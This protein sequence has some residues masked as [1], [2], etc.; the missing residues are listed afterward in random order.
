V[1]PALGLLV[2]CAVWTP[3]ASASPP[4]GGA[5]ASEASGT[6]PAE[7]SDEDRDAA[8][9]H[10]RRGKRHL[11]RGRFEEALEEFGQA[12]AL[13]PHWA[14]S[15]SMGVCHD[16]LGRPTDALRLY[17]QAL[18]EGGEEIPEQQREEL[19]TRVSALRI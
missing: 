16:R 12:Y 17:E 13:Y 6:A 5:T 15:N 11:D 19:Q 4:E 18:R 1:P 8:R 9:Q 3:P 7:V 2:V 10:Y 14:T